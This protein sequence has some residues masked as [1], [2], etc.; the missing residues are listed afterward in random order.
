MI[1]D[2]LDS[3]TGLTIFI[4]FIL[5]I[6]SA[7]LSGSE[8]ALTAASRIR[9][10]RLAQEGRRPAAWVNFLLDRQEQLLSAILLCNN[11]VNIL[12]SVLATSLF[13]R[14]FGE[15]GVIY[16]TIVMTVIVVI[17]AEV[18]P[19]TYAISS[20]DMTAMRVA[21]ILRV[22]IFILRPM[23]WL[24]QRISRLV[25][26]LAGIAEDEAASLLAPHDEI[27]GAIDLHHQ[28]GGVVK[29]DR[30]MLGGILDLRSISVGEVMNHR[31]N[32][33]MID[34]DLKAGDITRQMLESPYTRVPLWRDNPENIVGVLHAR[35]VLRALAASPSGAEGIDLASIMKPP[36]FVPETTSLS[37]QLNLFRREKAHFALVV[38]EYS[39]LMGLVTMEDILEEIVGHIHDEHD[40][41]EG[42]IRRLHDGSIE[43]RGEMSIRDVNRD[44]AWSLP[45]DEATTIAGLVIHESRTI[46]EVGQV[47]DFYGYRFRVMARQRN[48]ITTLRISKSDESRHRQG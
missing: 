48:Q 43:V 1:W 31:K 41:V 3:T 2:L 33:F 6:C 18:L 40:E 45:D 12:A 17:F 32:M 10:I 42:E 16:A 37:H 44:L 4:I 26:R 47:F 30:D 29:G 25:L 7:I 38:D 24:L 15:N 34:A 9:M 46:P 23:T 19:K 14:L 22:L 8:T 21:G 27:R 36:W 5:I 28:E 35:D 13:L 11:L 20:P 39:A